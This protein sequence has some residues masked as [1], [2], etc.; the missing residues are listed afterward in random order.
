MDRGYASQELIEFLSEN[1]CYLFRIRSK[2]S[3]EI[4][5]LPLGS[6][7]I[8]MYDNVKV[9]IIKFVLPS[10]EVETLMT[11]LF[12][13]NTSYYLPINILNKIHPISRRNMSN[14]RGFKR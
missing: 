8:T 12:D 1:A 4:D 10:G 5:A 6:H 3:T 14:R 7:I 13:L 2:F 9:R 11:N